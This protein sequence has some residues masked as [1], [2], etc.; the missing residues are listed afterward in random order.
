MLT[1][2]TDGWE[3]KVVTCSAINNSGV[4]EIWDN[5]LSFDRATKS[6]GAFDRRRNEQMLDWMHSMI[7]DRLNRKFYNNN[8]IKKV[9]PELE[10][11]VLSGKI[12]PAAAADELLNMM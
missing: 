9:I 1:P 3:T 10:S 5:I 2:A 7:R 11:R 6:S 12:T 8:E 4:D